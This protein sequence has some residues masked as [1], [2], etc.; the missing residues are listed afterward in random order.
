MNDSVIIEEDVVLGN[1]CLF[2]NGID[3]P[4]S[5]EISGVLMDL[6]NAKTSNRPFTLEF[7][8]EPVHYKNKPNDK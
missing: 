3:I 4:L 1:N 7:M 2:I 6:S 8:Y 5:I